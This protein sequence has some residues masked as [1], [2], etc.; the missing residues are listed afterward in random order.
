MADGKKSFVLYS[1]QKAIFDEL[2]DE[3]AGQLIKHIYSYVNDEDPVTDDQI[4]KISFTPIK[5]QLK[6]DLQKWEAQQNQ[7][8]EAGRK[9]AEKR[10]QALTELN[11]RSISSTVNGNVNVN[12]N[13]NVNNNKAFVADAN[14]NEKEYRLYLFNCIKQKESS[15]DALFKNN[16][17]NLSLRNQLWTDF[18][19]SAIMNSPIIEDDKHAWNMFKKFVT[20]NAAKY[21]KNNSTFEGF[22]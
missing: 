14:K 16:S 18:I 12:V 8:R 15:R 10:Q 19:E 22:G 17:I 4:I 11:E 2:T 6:R 9:S 3:Q 13:G 21:K 5:L 1:D 20:S 7:R